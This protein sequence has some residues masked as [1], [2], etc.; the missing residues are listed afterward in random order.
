MEKEGS[1]ILGAAGR[2]EFL[3]VLATGDLF[4]DQILQ[5]NSTIAPS[6]LDPK[7]EPKLKRAETPEFRPM[8]IRV[9]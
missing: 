4:R 9:N 1:R 7:K 8:K 6:T 5:P 2:L 3:V